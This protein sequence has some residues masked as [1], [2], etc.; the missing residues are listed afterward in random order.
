M[1]GFCEAEV[2]RGSGEQVV[3]VPGILARSDQQ[4]AP[5]RPMLQ[6]LGIN[7]TGLDYV[8]PRFEAEEC[9][10]NIVDAIEDSLRRG[11]PTTVVGLSL[12]GMLTAHALECMRDN[13]LS[14]EGLRVIIGDS[15]F[16]WR[17][18]VMTP[19]PEAGNRVVRRLFNHWNPSDRANSGYGKRLLK[20]FGQP[21][22]ADAIEIPPLQYMQEWDEA[23]F[24]AEEWR[25]AV[26]RW[27][28]S[29]LSGYD[30]TLWH[31]WVKWMLNQEQTPLDGLAGLDSVY[32]RC[33]RR[34][35]TVR[36]PQAGMKWGEGV[37][38]VLDVPTAHCGI[39]EGS[40]TWNS[41]MRTLLTSQH[42]TGVQWSEA[43][44]PL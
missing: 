25:S 28:V 4:S 14:R 34:N 7:V 38:R 30:F 43:G 39:L 12:G 17:D 11:C 21:P 2:L 23:V 19:V 18:I 36:Q 9:V 16:D 40:V 10:W 8:G 13:S 29:G 32:L 35:A 24:T 37:S 44:M 33:M 41:L 22:K 20:M 42:F 27:A 5:L 1:P 6:S 26:K 15:P 3:W 31:S